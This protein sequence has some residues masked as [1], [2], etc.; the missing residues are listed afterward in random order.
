MSGLNKAIID[1]HR[2]VAGKPK[3]THDQWLRL[4]EHQCNLRI[5]LI[6]EAKRDLFEK[7]VQK[8]AEIEIQNE[9]RHKKMLAWEERKLFGDALK[10]EE[11][12]RK[13]QRG[14]LEKELKNQKGKQAFKRWLKDSLIK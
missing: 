13:H 5:A 11:E 1:Q 2:E 4:K 12:K 3:L 7:L 8:Q 10:L 6:A 14:K 9:E